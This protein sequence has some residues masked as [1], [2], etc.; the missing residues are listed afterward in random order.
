MP[1]RVPLSSCHIIAGLTLALA[2]L[3]LFA[4]LG[5][6]AL[7]DDEAY[8]A[9]AAEGILR[10]GDTSAV[11]DHNIVAFRHGILPNDKLKDRFQPPLP[12]Y[13]TAPFIAMFNHTAFAARLP[14]AMSGVAT[15]ALMLWC[16]LRLQDVAWASRPRARR[17]S[18]SPQL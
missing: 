6:Y 16:V 9:L 11:L 17:D 7:W 8:T 5:H 18:G 4:R 1:R 3:L 13:V 10:S 12:A 15:V 14:T 2:A